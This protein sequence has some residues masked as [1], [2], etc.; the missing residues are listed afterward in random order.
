MNEVFYDFSCYDALEFE[1]S[2]IR[3]VRDFLN[4][5]FLLDIKNSGFTESEVTHRMNRFLHL[6]VVARVCQLA[7]TNEEEYQQAQE[8][9]YSRTDEIMKSIFKA[10]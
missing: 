8:I 4:E 1:I 10:S 2:C 9:V 6:M 7:E 5:L 3:R